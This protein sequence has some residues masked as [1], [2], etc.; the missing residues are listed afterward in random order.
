MTNELSITVTARRGIQSVSARELH[1]KLGIKSQFTHW[2]D[3]MCEY[4]FEEEKDFKAISQKKLTAQGNTSEYIDYAISV[5]MAKEICMI[6]RSEIGKKFRQYFIE[7]EKR[8]IEQNTAEYKELR[9]KSKDIRKTFTNALQE[10][11]CDKFYHYI[12]ITNAMKKPLGITAKKGD[13]TKSE[14]AKIVAAESLAEAVL[15]DE[16]GYYQVKPTCV[17]ASNIVMTA[18]TENK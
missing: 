13:M 17:N 14:L 1:Q 15:Y 18:I 12:N 6:Q 11:G 9:S 16:V 8:Y 7:I 2:F 10:H 3:K 5:D 4:G